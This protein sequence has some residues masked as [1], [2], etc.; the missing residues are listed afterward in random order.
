[1]RL[2]RL[3]LPMPQL[4][5]EWLGALGNRTVWLYVAYTAVLFVVF[6][7]MT[8]PHDM[9]MR[10]AL[11]VVGGGGDGIQFTGARFAW[12]RGYEL[13]GIRIDGP[14]GASA[15]LLEVSRFWV[16]PSL[17]ALLR[18]NPYAASL[19]ADLY[20]GRAEGTID[21]TAGTLA[22]DLS[23]QAVEIGRY[24]TITA[25]LQEGQVAGRLSGH[26][27]FES[28]GN[29]IE[30]VQAGGDIVID[31]AALSGV[32]VEGFTVPDLAL[33]QVRLKF[34]LRGGRLEVTELVANGDA[35]V[36]GSGQ[37]VLRQ[38]I[39]DSALNLRATILPTAT[40]PE[41]VKTLISLIPRPPGS[42]PDAPLTVT[43]TLIRPRVR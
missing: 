15:P 39:Q 23:W 1:M 38:P 36:Q 41:A 43:G 22:G 6:L 24:R 19:Q 13:D 33:K 8:F 7:L 27:D 4:S 25:L 40:T 42:K 5:F 2:P 9:I 37:V 3:S 17:R 10:R 11:D 12:H 16:R 32:K 30:A 26:V 29:S 31:G 21:Y 14:D 20:G 35:N 34:A 18:G 28:R